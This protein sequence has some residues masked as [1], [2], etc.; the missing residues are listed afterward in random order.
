M[1][2]TIPK[3]VTRKIPQVVRK[4]L[5]D[6]HPPKQPEMKDMRG[7]LTV[8]FVMSVVRS[9]LPSMPGLAAADVFNLSGFL[10]A[11]VLVEA[12]KWASSQEGAPSGVL[13]DAQGIAARALKAQA[14]LKKETVKKLEAELQFR[15]KSEV[16]LNRKDPKLPDLETKLKGE[17]DLLSNPKKVAEERSRRASIRLLAKLL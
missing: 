3:P 11:A 6:L 7:K 13:K 10:N 5:P 16:R 1:P 9:V 4:E 8:P 14:R 15:K 17:Q 12:A 2:D